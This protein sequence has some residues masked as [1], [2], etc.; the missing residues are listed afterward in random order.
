MKIVRVDI[1]YNKDL[2][3]QTAL[4]VCGSFIPDCFVLFLAVNCNALAKAGAVSVLFRV[5][6][7]CGHKRVICLK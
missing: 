6:T 2:L 5:V 1:S 4:N 3:L 7:S